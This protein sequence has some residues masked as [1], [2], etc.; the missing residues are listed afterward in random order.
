MRLNKKR[1]EIV[2]QRFAVIGKP[3]AHSL[4]PII[5]QSF[6][7]QTQQTMTYEKIQ[8][9]ELVFE[10]QVSTFFSSG[11]KGLNVTLPF[12]QRAFAMAEVTSDRCAKAGAAN[13]LWLDDGKIHADN[14]DGI[15][16]VRDLARYCPLA[17]KRIL[18]LGAGGAARGIIHPLLESKPALLTVANRSFDK[19]KKLQSEFPEIA[20]LSLEH[21]SGTFDLIINASSAGHLGEVISLPKEMMVYTPFCYDLAYQQKKDTPFVSYTRGFGCRAIDGLGMLVEQAAEAFYL[22]HGVR[23]DVSAILQRLR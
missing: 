10:Q 18:I 13:T 12:K 4:S 17:G 7:K 15:G 14:T 11:G 9:D 16:F 1:N 3:I 8:G 23:P 19:V 5:H 2:L 6:A 21:L 20:V 22:W